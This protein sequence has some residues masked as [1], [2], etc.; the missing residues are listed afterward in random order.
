MGVNSVWLEPEACKEE[1]TL[2]GDMHKRRGLKTKPGGT[3][4]TQRSRGG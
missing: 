1:V 4:N 2:G 3:L